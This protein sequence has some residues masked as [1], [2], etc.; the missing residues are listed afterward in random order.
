[1]AYP[2]DVHVRLFGPVAAW[3]GTTAVPLG[4]AR[5]RTV[6]AL[7]AL[8]AGRPVSRTDLVDT[9]W[10]DGPPRRAANVIQTYVKGLRQALEPGRPPRYPSGTLVT[11][12]DGYAL[13]IPPGQVDAL[14]FR[15]LVAAARVARRAGDDGRV[16]RLLDPALGMWRAP[17]LPDTPL[18]SGHP[19]VTVIEAERWTAVGWYAQAALEL[20]T[21]DDALTTVEEAAAQRPLDESIHGWLI[22]LYRAVG[23]RADALVAYQ[24]IRDRL[25][26]DLGVDPVPEL[27]DLYADAFNR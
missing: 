8:A 9:L 14:R 6:L 24:R 13:R 17:L 22:R 25:A 21:A 5:Q 19:S 15:E 3:R 26:E 4:S 16:A 23:R 2:S 27:A 1:M 18:L 10:R 20:G 12:G 11:V 7:L